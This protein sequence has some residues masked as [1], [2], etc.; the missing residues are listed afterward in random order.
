MHDKFVLP[1]GGE[2]SHAADGFRLILDVHDTF[3]RLVNR[4]TL[5]ALDMPFPQASA[6]VQL[7]RSGG[8]SCGELAKQLGY[9]TG[10]VS[11]LTH[12]LESR[13]LIVR[14]RNGKDRR[15]M[16]L[17]LTPTGLTTAAQA[18]PLLMEAENAILRGFSAEERMFLKGLIRRIP[19][20]N[21]L[22]QE[23]L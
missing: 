5:A 22:I 20:V 4:K 18:S 10:H 7:A 21:K 2:K 8:V 3:K 11:R 19:Q 17:A 1:G 15:V 6:L 12:D 13:K 14:R 16:D 9:D 23:I